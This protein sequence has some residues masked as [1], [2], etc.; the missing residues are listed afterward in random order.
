MVCKN[1]LK[2]ITHLLYNILHADA[3]RR[4]T[5]I[6]GYQ[7]PDLFLVTEALK[8]ARTQATTRA[9]REISME[10]YRDRT[11]RRANF[12]TPEMY[13]DDLAQR[14]EAV[15]EEYV[16]LLHGINEILSYYKFFISIQKED[17]VHRS[18]YG[19]CPAGICG[20]KHI[21]KKSEAAQNLKDNRSVRGPNFMNREEQKS[22]EARLAKFSRLDEKA[23][24]DLERGILITENPQLI[25]Q[26]EQVSYQSF[27]LRYIKYNYCN[28][29]RIWDAFCW[30][31]G[32]WGE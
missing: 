6:A 32:S 30:V 23:A 10:L 14:P 22:V 7:S 27:Y 29:Y 17:Q 3:V 2:I 16:S 25:A 15:F 26:V 12:W 8:T 28:N 24:S 21:T 11:S 31:L 13:S 18:K 9:D 5:V 19:S 20:D 1:H 4:R